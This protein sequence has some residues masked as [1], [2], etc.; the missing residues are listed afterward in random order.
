EQMQTYADI[1]AAEC[2]RTWRTIEF[3][4]NVDISA[5][6][7]E[8]DMAVRMP[9]ATEVSA[10]RQLLASAGAPP[11]NGYKE[12][13]LIYGRETVL[14]SETFPSRVKT[15]V[16][17]LRVGNLGIATYPGEAFVEMGLDL[18]SKSPFK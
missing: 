11:P 12:Q 14:L 18:N 3:R 13:P 7:E 4:D 8:L 5:S 16:Q 6:I 9:S 1:L 15:F 2:Y 10:A 17:A